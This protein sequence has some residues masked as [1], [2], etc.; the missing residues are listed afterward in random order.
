MGGILQEIKDIK[1]SHFHREGTKTAK[2]RKA[3]RE[4]PGQAKFRSRKLMLRR[5]PRKDILF[6]PG[7]KFDILSPNPLQRRDKNHGH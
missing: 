2:K 3:S 4:K 5:S 6:V 7:L 1:R